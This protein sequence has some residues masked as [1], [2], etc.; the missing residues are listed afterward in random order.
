VVPVTFSSSHARAAPA[1]RYTFPN[2]KRGCMIF[3]HLLLLL[4]CKLRHLPALLHRLSQ[5]R[6]RSG[7]HHPI[8]HSGATRWTQASLNSSGLRQSARSRSRFRG[9]H[10]SRGR[11]VN[12]WR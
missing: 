6:H 2:R 5:A 12:T 3:R 9:R 8:D 4:P 10:S 11:A 1:P 7:P